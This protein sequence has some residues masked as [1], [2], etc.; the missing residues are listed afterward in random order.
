LKTHVGCFVKCHLCKNLKGTQYGI[1]NMEMIEQSQRIFGLTVKTGNQ[2]QYATTEIKIVITN[3][4]QE[5][6]RQER[7][8]EK[9][10][11]NDQ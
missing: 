6:A 9:G 7:R 4:H 1:A 2:D 3:L 10:V 8:G 11:M 5:E